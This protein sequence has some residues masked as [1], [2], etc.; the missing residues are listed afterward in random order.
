MPFASR[1]AIS[2]RVSASAMTSVEAS[3]AL[4]VWSGVVRTAVEGG[5]GLVGGGFGRH[6]WGWEG[7]WERGEGGLT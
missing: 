5:G 4:G 7:R 3:A 6:G 2:E 1:V